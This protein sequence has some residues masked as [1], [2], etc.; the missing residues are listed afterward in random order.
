MEFSYFRNVFALPLMMTWGIMLPMSSFYTNLETFTINIGELPPIAEKKIIDFNTCN[1]EVA[2]PSIIPDSLILKNTEPATPLTISRMFYGSKAIVGKNV[3][4]NSC[5]LSWWHAVLSDIH[6][7]RTRG[8]AS[9]FKAAE[10]VREQI[11]VSM[12]NH[13]GMM[14]NGTY[15]S[16]ALEQE[17][18]TICM[19]P[20]SLMGQTEMRV[21]I[22]EVRKEKVPFSIRHDSYLST[23]CVFY[24]CLENLNREFALNSTNMEVF[25]EMF[26]ASI[27]HKLGAHNESGFKDFF[28]GLLIIG[29]RGHLSVMMNTHNGV[30]IIRMDNRKPNTTGAGYI[31][32][33]LNQLKEIYGIEVGIAKKDNKMLIFCNQ[34]WTRGAIEQMS[35]MVMVNGVLNSLPPRELNEMECVILE[36][37]GND[38]QPLIKHGIARDAA[39]M[40]QRV[41]TTV[42]PNKTNERMTAEKEQITRIPIL[43]MC[44][45]CLDDTGEVWPTM[46]AVLH[47]AAPGVSAYRSLGGKRPTK[48]TDIG[49]DK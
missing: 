26:L 1:L 17:F 29:G 15:R 6:S 32:E 39:S 18:Q 47:V 5:M 48:A 3:K 33:K 35:C 25:L 16:E 43:A 45:N 14:M 40:G 27:H 24:G 44:S 13:A 36:I 21:F 37:R 46:A 28:H 22:N 10:L 19:L 2:D 38:L 9:P 30:G 20:K 12:K 31:Q 23:T 11:R 4:T 34:Q 42:D 8:A 7:Q 49:C 41:V